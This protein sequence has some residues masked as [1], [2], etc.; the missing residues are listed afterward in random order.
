MAPISAVAG[1][2]KILRKTSCTTNVMRYN[3]RMNRRRTILP[4]PGRVPV[5]VPYVPGEP[6]SDTWRTVLETGVDTV[7]PPRTTTAVEE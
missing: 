4:P 1:P 6:T 7:R 3:R 5:L 2:M